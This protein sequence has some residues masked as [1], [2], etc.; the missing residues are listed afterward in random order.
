M[1][2]AFTS[3]MSFAQQWIPTHTYCKQVTPTGHLSDGSIT[4]PITR[5]ST[6]DTSQHSSIAEQGCQNCS[7][8]HSLSTHGHRHQQWPIKHSRCYFMQQGVEY[9]VQNQKQPMSLDPQLMRQILILKQ[10]TAGCLQMCCYQVRN[11][12]V[13]WPVAEAKLTAS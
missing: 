13:R 4:Q 6:Q 5:N 8:R 1:L 12:N 10:N 7:V 11:V 9:H 2:R 3:A